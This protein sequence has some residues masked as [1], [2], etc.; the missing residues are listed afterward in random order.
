MLQYLPVALLAIALFVSIRNLITG[1][2]AKL[3]LSAAIVKGG[4][5]LAERLR[6]LVAADDLPGVVHELRGHL[7][8]LPKAERESAEEGLCQRSESGRRF[9]AGSVMKRGL[10]QLEMTTSH[11]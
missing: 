6:G 9:Y 4:P 8:A 2:R 5:E 11:S 10:R 7:A 3:D 1:I